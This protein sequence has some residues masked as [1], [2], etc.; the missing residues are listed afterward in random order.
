LVLQTVQKDFTLEDELGKHLPAI[1]VFSVSIRYLKDHLLCTC[2]KEAPDIRES[3]IR[4]VLTVPA[5]WNEPAKQFM[6]ES[7]V[8]VCLLVI[9]VLE[10]ILVKKYMRA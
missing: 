3:D 2:Q 10:L 9:N 6:R 7:A 8:Q 5:I 1:D 4:W